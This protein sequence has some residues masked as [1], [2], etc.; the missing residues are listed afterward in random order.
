MLPETI[1]LAVDTANTGSTTDLDYTRHDDTSTPNKSTYVSENHTLTSRDKLDFYRR[2][3]TRSG[4]SFGV[5]KTSRKFTMDVTVP[6]TDGSDLVVPMIR[7]VEDSF[8]VG[9]TAAQQ[10]EFRQ[11]SNALEDLDSVMTLVHG[12]QAI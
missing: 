8:P 10:L 5:A 4:N 12:Q 6:G 11:R 3:A 7:T 2:Y 1:T 9:V